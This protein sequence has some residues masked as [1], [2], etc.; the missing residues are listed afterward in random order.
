MTRRASGS[1]GPH[2]RT[3]ELEFRNHGI[4][5]ERTDEIAARFDEAVAGAEC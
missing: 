5:G 2:L 1:T 3:P 4:Y